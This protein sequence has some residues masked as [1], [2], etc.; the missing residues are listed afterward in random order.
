MTPTAIQ[1]ADGATSMRRILALYYSLLAGACF[2]LGAINGQMAG[3]YSG[4][5]CAGTSLIF[6]GMTTISDIVALWKTA[7]G[8]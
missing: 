1:E 2:I 3:F 8:S 6:M 4:I 5:G 7:K